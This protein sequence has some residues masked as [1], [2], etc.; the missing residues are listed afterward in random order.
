MSICERCIH[1]QLQLCTFEERRVMRW[2][3]SAFTRSFADWC[4]TEKLTA[5]G[6][7]TA[8]NDLQLHSHSLFAFRRTVRN[9]EFVCYAVCC[10][11]VCVFAVLNARWFLPLAMCVCVCGGYDGNRFPSSIKGIAWSSLSFFF[12]SFIRPKAKENPH[13]V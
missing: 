6:H 3:R 9:S 12:R 2:F 4:E 13:I 5:S 11:C 10:V 1:P 7:K 8:S